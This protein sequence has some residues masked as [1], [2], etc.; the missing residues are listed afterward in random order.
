M[1]KLLR[2]A[3]L[4]NFQT[5]NFEAVLSKAAAAGATFGQTLDD[6]LI[7]MGLLHNR[8]I[9]ASRLIS[10]CLEDGHKALHQL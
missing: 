6:V 7:T 5:R 10:T 1:D 2:I 8:N 4:T 3:Q 9:D